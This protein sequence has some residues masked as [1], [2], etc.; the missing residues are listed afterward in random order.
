MDHA[1]GTVFLYNMGAICNMK[2]ILCD[3]GV[4]YVV[5]GFAMR[6]R[7]ATISLCNMGEL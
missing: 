4:R 7:C 1:K 6:Y 2:S 3:R 5:W